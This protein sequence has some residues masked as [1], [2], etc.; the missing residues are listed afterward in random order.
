VTVRVVLVENEEIVRRGLRRLLELE[1]GVEVVGEARDGE[2]AL[3][4]IRSARPEVVLL[5]LRMPRLDGIGVLEALRG[6]ATASPSGARLGPHQV[7]CLILTTFDDPDAL[8]RAARA[9]ARGWL[10][11]DAP[12][13]ELAAAIREVAGGGTYLQPALTSG[14]LRGFEAFGGSVEGAEP[15][16]PLT[17]REHDVLRLMAGGYANKEIG[18]L[19]G[20]SE[21]TVKNHVS[22]VLGKL[23][24]RDRTRAVL[25]AL[26]KRL[27]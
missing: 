15:A 4:V 9:G 8:L 10:L 25:K 5:D 22:S 3:G 20:V 7:P 2:E 26:E 16:E 23:G 12:V 1:G 6:E 24:V 19:L 14:L 21:R 18:D 13:E 11:K 27:I 17:E